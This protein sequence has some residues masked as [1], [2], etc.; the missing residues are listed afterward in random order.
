[1]RKRWA[2]FGKKQVWLRFVSVSRFCATLRK[3]MPRK[4]LV[5]P[6]GEGVVSYLAQKARLA[7]ET[8]TASKTRTR[9]SGPEA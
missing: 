8:D 7:A 2:W 9:S 3:K 5:L 4:S 1:M 6:S